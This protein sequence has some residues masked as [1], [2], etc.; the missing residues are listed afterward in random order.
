MTSLCILT[1]LCTM[2]L[3]P[4]STTRLSLRLYPQARVSSNGK[5]SKTSQFAL[6][7]RLGHSDT[8]LADKRRSINCSQISLVGQFPALVLVVPIVAANTAICKSNSASEYIVVASCEIDHSK[9]HSPQLDATLFT[10]STR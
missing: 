10:R 6:L 1:C 7:G 4:G 3:L 2:N 8:S 5:T 9:C